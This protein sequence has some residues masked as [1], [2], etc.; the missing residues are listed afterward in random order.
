[1]FVA[2]G[3]ELGFLYNDA[4]A[5]IL[6]AKHPRALGR[7]FTTSGRKSGATSALSSTRP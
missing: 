2:W 5:E 4:Y 3:E 1:M 6:G 7:R